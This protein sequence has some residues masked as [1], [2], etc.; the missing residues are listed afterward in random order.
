MRPRVAWM[1]GADDRILEFFEEHRIALSPAT[2]THHLDY[3]KTHIN[4]RMRK[5]ADEGFLER[6]PDVRGLY[7]ITDLGL[8][9]LA[10]E[11]EAEELEDGE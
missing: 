7:R 8:A 11:V 4:N 3:S 10:G 2:L 1:T 9:Y 5:L 6:V